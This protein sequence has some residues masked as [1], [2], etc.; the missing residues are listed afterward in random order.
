MTTT[1]LPTPVQ[2]MLQPANVEGELGFAVNVTDVPW[3]NSALQ[4][5]GQL[6]AGGALVIIPLPVAVT[7]S[8]I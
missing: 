4:V 8:S 5:T 3:E 6:M 2:S 7:V 1:Q